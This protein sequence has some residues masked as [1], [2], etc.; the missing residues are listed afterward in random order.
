MLRIKIPA[1]ELYDENKE[2]FVEIANQDLVLE[3]SLFSVSRWESRWKKPFF[4]N[5]KKT[6]EESVD[7]VRCMALNEVDPLVYKNLPASIFP[8]IDDYIDDPMTATTFNSPKRTRKKNGS[9]ITSEI[10]YY[11]MAS[12]NIPFECDRW[13]LNRLLALIQ[14][15][16]IKNSP[17]AK[18]GKAE[19]AQMYS[20][21]NQAR[22]AKLGTT[23]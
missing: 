11:W 9:V 19:V 8:V 23:G 5:E 2:E 13:H 17:P 14:V 22:R 6:E 12:L 16:I 7:Y 1:I 10:L 15:G 20:S 21:L 18:M 3:H 4:S